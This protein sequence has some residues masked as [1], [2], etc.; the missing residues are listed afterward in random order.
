MEPLEEAAP[1]RLAKAEID[2]AVS[3]ARASKAEVARA[4]LDMILSIRS[5]HVVRV[6][7]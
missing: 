7:S 6:D 3:V 2:A 1:E 5:S 4:I